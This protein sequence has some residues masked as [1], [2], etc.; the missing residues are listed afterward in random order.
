M[1]DDDMEKRETEL[2]KRQEA[3]DRCHARNL[4]AVPTQ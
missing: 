3:L 1:S 4:I 2:N